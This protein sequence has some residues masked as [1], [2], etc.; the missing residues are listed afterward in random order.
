MKREDSI[1]LNKNACF[2]I[3]NSN[4]K[5]LHLISDITTVKGEANMN[6]YTKDFNHIICQLEDMKKRLVFKSSIDFYNIEM[7]QQDLTNISIEIDNQLIK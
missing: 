4:L 3:D 5:N 7:I 2:K 6:K 1:T